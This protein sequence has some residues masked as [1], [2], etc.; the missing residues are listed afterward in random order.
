M[1]EEQAENDTPTNEEEVVEPESTEKEAPEEEPASTPDDKELKSALAQ[2]DHFREKFEKAEKE[3]KALEE[4]LRKAAAAGTNPDRASLDV[5]DYI[6]ISNALSGL[7]REQ[8]AY[9][10]EQHKL[11]GKPLSEIRESAAFKR[12]DAGYQAEQEAE[13]ALHPNSAQP[14]ADLPKS[15]RE[16]LKGASLAEKEKL[17][18]EM[19]LW[20]HPSP[21]SDRVKI[22]DTRVG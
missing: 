5:E 22:G 1:N 18:A 20:K 16:K 9:L 17:L 7:D 13:R 15:A 3:R 11:T 14:E 8:Q 2:K 12:W 6:D 19:G 10:S 21:K 4:R